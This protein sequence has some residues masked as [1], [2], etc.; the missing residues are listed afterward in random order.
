[1]AIIITAQRVR[2]RISLFKGWLEA[3]IA[4]IRAAGR[5]V[6]G[7]WINNGRSREYG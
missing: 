7:N 6:D 2:P 4:A 1:M 5:D 3:S